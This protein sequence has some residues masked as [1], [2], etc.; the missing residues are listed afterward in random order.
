MLF[1]KAPL[2]T[3]FASSEKLK[4]ARNVPGNVIFTVKLLQ[5]VNI[6]N[7]LIIFFFVLIIFFSV[8]AG[9]EQRKTVVSVI[10]PPRFFTPP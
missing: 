5:R 3:F 6:V 7:F 1:S 2:L 8:F 9:S 10:P 4:N